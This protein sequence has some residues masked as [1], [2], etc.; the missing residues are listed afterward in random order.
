MRRENRE[1][2]EL[3]IEKTNKLKALSFTESAQQVKVNLS[4]N[5]DDKIMRSE[6]TGPNSEQIDAFILTYRFFIQDNKQD[7]VHC[8]FRWLAKN[9]L[10]DPDVSNHWKEEFSKARN[11]FN[12]FLDENPSIP[13][14]LE[15]EPLLTRREIMEMFV[16]GDLS[17]KNQAK[18]ELFKKRMSVPVLSELHR[19]EFSQILHVVLNEIMVFV[20]TLSAA[21]LEGRL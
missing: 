8:S 11:S 16:Y 7:D 14:I 9:V 4:W 15:G 10:D 3:F 12:Q 2:L 5:S 1:A 6:L 18:L 13:A 20:A 21:E 17:H 19:R